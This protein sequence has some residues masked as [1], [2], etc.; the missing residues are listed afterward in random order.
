MINHHGLR[1]GAFWAPPGGGVEFGQSVSENLVREFQEETNLRVEVG[2]YLFTCEFIHPPLHAVEMFFAVRVLGGTLRA[3]RDPEIN[4]RDQIIKEA[5]FMTYAD[6]DLLPP[7]EKHGAFQLV[8]GAVK[9]HTLNG[10]YKI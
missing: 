1:G 6:I 10:Y 3:G 5:R 7:E 9:I 2:A 8:S 4:S